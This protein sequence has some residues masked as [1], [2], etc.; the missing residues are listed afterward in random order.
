MLTNKFVI[1]VRWTSK[2]FFPDVPHIQLRLV[3]ILGT[4]TL[5]LDVGYFPTHLT[6][7]RKFAGSGEMLEKEMD[8]PV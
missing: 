6:R 3:H 5:D 8:L 4:N 7:A 1:W 2:H